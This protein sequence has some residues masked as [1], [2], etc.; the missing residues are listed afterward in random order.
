MILA[1]ESDKSKTLSTRRN[2]PD[3]DYEID[4]VEYEAEL[5]KE[6]DNEE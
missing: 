6:S 1:E 3:S 4:N 5:D 2:P